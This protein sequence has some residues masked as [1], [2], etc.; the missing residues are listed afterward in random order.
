MST[1][2]LFLT[3]S[4][5]NGGVFLSVVDSRIH[6]SGNVKILFRHSNYVGPHT[7][8]RTSMCY[9]NPFFSNQVAKVSFSPPRFSYPD[10][11]ECNLQ[12]HTCWNHSVCVNLPGGYD[13]VC[14]SG[15]GCSGD[16]QQ[17]KGIRRNGEDWKPSFDRCA[18]C[19][20]KVEHTWTHFC[21][22]PFFHCNSWKRLVSM[23]TLLKHS[24]SR[25]CLLHTLSVPW[26]RTGKA[27]R[28]LIV[29]TVATVGS[30][31]ILLEV[32]NLKVWELCWAGGQ[33]AVS[34]WWTCPLDVC[35]QWSSQFITGDFPACP[36]P[37]P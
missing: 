24:L 7:D 8:S 37:D 13:C 35:I 18:L 30:L 25:D 3:W 23:A 16:C 33:S 2:M 17:D 26:E 31:F 32:K 9:K 1:R 28:W 11:D 27:F 14:T 6:F 12:T 10:V 29:L 21:P 22:L 34:P 36:G 5:L 15:P 20:C 19:S 4:V